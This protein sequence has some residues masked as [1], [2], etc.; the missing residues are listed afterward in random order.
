MGDGERFWE[1]F[2]SVEC[3]VGLWSTTH[4]SGGG[5]W[6]VTTVFNC[7]KYPIEVCLHAEIQRVST[8]YTT[9]IT[10]HCY[11]AKITLCSM[12]GDCRTPVSQHCALARVGYYFVVIK[13]TFDT[14]SV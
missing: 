3:V 4:T 7:F 10:N 9:E 2:T 8:C 12:V 11:A 5:G 1:M 6:V 14:R 13:N